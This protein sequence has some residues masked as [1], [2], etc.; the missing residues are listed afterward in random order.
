MTH[1]P[2]RLRRARGFTLVEAITVVVIIGIIGAIVAVFIRAPI[3]GY[4][5]TVAR[6]ELT[7]QADLAL[8]RMARDIRL[9]LPNSVRVNAAGDH[10]EFLQTRSGAR[11]ISVEDGIDNNLALR[12]DNPAQTAFAALAPPASFGQVRAGD[13]VVVTNL[14]MGFAPA[15][16]YD[17]SSACVSAGSGTGAGNIAQITRI[18]A[19]STAT[20]NTDAGAV[21]LPVRGITLAVNPFACQSIPMVSPRQRFQVVSGPVSFFCTDAGNGTFT[22]WRAWDYPINAVQTIPS[23]GKRAMLAAGLTRCNGLFNAD[24]N[25]ALQRTG[26][27]LLAIDMQ[28]RNADA[29]KIRLVHQVHVD[30]TP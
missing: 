27:V 9:A 23:T 13:Y 3:I 2:Y 15:N 10:L 12:F 22:L 6:A 14:G 30:N 21:T 29:G 5:D 24:G 7:D 17:L 8:R 26:L 20:V 4:R 28:G 19:P 18:D 11:Y 25:V 16:A 1:R